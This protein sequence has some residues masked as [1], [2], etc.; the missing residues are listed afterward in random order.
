MLSLIREDIIYLQRVVY[1]EQI[2]KYCSFSN[3]IWEFYKSITWYSELLRVGERLV[4]LFDACSP[5]IRFFR[6]LSS[7]FSP[8]V[9]IED[10]VCRYN[11]D[12]MRSSC[13]VLNTTLRSTFSEVDGIDQPSE[14]S[15]DLPL[16]SRWK[17]ST[18]WNIHGI[19]LHTIDGSDQPSEISMRSAFTQ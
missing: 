2:L 13:W 14:I 11:Y 15:C 7:T 3:P 10:L 6:S 12:V 1:N 9:F 18:I 16:H 19:Y 4:A 5:K 8:H 17:W